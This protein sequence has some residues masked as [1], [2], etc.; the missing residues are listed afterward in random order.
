MGNQEM[1]PLLLRNINARMIVNYG[2]WKEDHARHQMA[3]IRRELGIK[4]VSI[5]RFC[6]FYKI[7]PWLFLPKLKE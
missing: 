1:N 2:L 7:D 4:H 5:Y 6:Q 3:K